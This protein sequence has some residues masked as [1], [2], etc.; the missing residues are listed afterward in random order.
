METGDRP[1]FYESLG[2]LVEAANQHYENTP[3]DET[4]STLKCE[5]SPDTPNVQVHYLVFKISGVT[6][7]QVQIEEEKVFLIL[8][9]LYPKV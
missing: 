5:I 2:G 6:A 8:D 4:P 1:V 7:I 3:L 9:W